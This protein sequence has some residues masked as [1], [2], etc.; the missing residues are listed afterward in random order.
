MM[1]VKDQMETNT[2]ERMRSKTEG[3][4]G[5]HQSPRQEGPLR[6]GKGVAMW[7]KITINKN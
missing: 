2:Q 7:I 3:K 1:G 5:P 4:A 6:G